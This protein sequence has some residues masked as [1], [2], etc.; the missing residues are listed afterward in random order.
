MYIAPEV[1]KKTGH[2]SEAD[3]WTL[4]VLIYEMLMGYTKGPQP[5]PEPFSFS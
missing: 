4:G 5:Y 1:L 2:G 3:W